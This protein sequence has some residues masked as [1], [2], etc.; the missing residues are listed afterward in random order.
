MPLPQIPVPPFIDEAKLLHLPDSSTSDIIYLDYS[1]TNNV[2]MRTLARAIVPSNSSQP[3]TETTL[4]LTSPTGLGLRV[5]K[6]LFASTAR[7]NGRR[8]IADLSFGINFS[9]PDRGLMIKIKMGSTI[10]F[11]WYIDPRTAGRFPSGMNSCVDLKGTAYRVSG[12]DN[13]V[14][15]RVHSNWNVTGY[16]ASTLA[17]ENSQ[18]GGGMGYE[19]YPTAFDNT[20]DQALTLTMAWDTIPAAN[21]GVVS[22]TRNRFGFLSG[23]ATYYISSVAG[24]NNNQQ[25]F[26]N[27]MDIGNGTNIPRGVATS[28]SRILAVGTN[29]YITVSYDGGKN[30]YTVYKLP[31]GDLYCA[32]YAKHL[33]MWIVAGSNG[34]V[35]TSTDLDTWTSR[36]ASV[37]TASILNCANNATRG[38]IV[39]ADATS[40]NYSVS[41]DGIT[42]AA[43]TIGTAFNPTCIVVN[44]ANVL[45]GGRTG[46]WGFY[47][48]TSWTYGTTG[49]NDFRTC[50]YDA[51]INK[52]AM[53]GVSGAMVYSSDGT[54]WTNGTW[55]TANTGTSYCMTSNGTVAVVSGTNGR[56]DYS[57]D[58]ITWTQSLHAQAGTFWGDVA[59]LY[60][61]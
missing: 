35:Y 29:G 20:V 8:L 39:I 45:V 57:T 28:G 5:P 13:A 25:L 2:V 56:I 26:G 36:T 4:T 60:I 50:H 54:T 14:A 17:D 40:N 44:G 11:Q 9:H 49:S 23:R 12:A 19:T 15:L 34:A 42:W 16:Y 31:S 7:A 6:G 3:T 55:V 52:Y 51:T 10:I 1:G 41:S 43:Q 24:V 46:K 21:Y 59:T 58:M 61:E 27:N 48:G 38:C 37:G 32:T 47:N 53:S 22:M 33:G 30:W 18:A